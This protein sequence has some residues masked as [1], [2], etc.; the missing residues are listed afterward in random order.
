MYVVVIAWLYVV[1]MAAVAEVVSS[2]GTVLGAVITFGLYGLLPLGIVVYI[3]GTPGRKR[4]LKARQLADRAHLAPP[5]GADGA[6]ATPAV[7]VSSDTPDADG[8]TTAGP[9]TGT[10]PP[11]GKEA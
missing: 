7:P 8:K 2:T 10:V 9:Q 1:L 6:S 4:A 5:P 11:V 3:M